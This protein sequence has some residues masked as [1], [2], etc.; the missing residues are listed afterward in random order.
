MTFNIKAG[1]GVKLKGM[2]SSWDSQP[3]FTETPKTYPATTD[4]TSF[5]EADHYNTYDT[6]STTK[7]VSF[8][9]TNPDI[10]FSI[11]QVD[12]T[13]YPTWDIVD[14]NHIR[15]LR[16]VPTI[17]M[18]I[19]NA[20]GVRNKKLNYLE[21]QNR[22]ANGLGDY[23]V[24]RTGTLGG[25][26]ERVTRSLLPPNGATPETNCRYLDQS[27]Y[28]IGLFDLKKNEDFF[29]KHIDISGVSIAGDDIEYFAYPMV[30][31]TPQHALF[32]THT[33]PNPLNVRMSFEASDGTIETRKIIAYKI[34]PPN[35][36][37]ET[38]ITVVYFEEP[39]VKIKPIKIMPDDIHQYTPSLSFIEEGSNPVPGVSLPTL[40]IP[41]FVSAANSGTGVNGPGNV[42]IPWNTPKWL[43]AS[44][45]S[46]NLKNAI[47]QV[48]QDVPLDPLLK[49]HWR[50]MYGGD[51]ASP[52]IGFLSEQLGGEIEPIY[53]A[54]L[55]RAGA[56]VGTG[57]SIETNSGLIQQYMN[58]LVV[59]NNG[60]T[61]YQLR[62]FNLGRFKK[63]PLS[64]I[65]P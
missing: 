31:V 45:G 39:F 14:G 64:D 19:E 52:F 61:L 62:R 17:D 21:T 41:I 49:S 2:P 23:T 60:G 59:E 25:E 26:F 18:K 43:A 1:G 53:F 36:A 11:T 47:R 37:D 30:L 44:L 32:A 34:L 15:K 42:V 4:K 13:E 63:Y 55:F 8:T 6:Y 35:P 7:E 38:D 57:G 56:G 48:P 50:A 33:R 3:V 51:S 28:V 5:V 9:T 58:D 10:P 46:I 12:G 22:E 40:D 54:S 65:R 29:L 24:H 16:G 20:Y 27:S